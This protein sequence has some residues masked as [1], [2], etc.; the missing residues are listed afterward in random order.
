MSSKYSGWIA[1]KS[2][3]F[4]FKSI[5][6]DPVFTN[7]YLGEHFICQVCKQ[8]RKG[9]SV[10]VQGPMACGTGSKII[11]RLVDGFASRW[12]AIEYA[13][14]VHHLTALTYNSND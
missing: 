9:W 10:I 11:P 3:S 2:Y 14:K 6:N 1:G 4:S 8:P 5:G 7:V 13:L 12:S